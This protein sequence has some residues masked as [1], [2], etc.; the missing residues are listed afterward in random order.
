MMS[1]ATAGGVT[2]GTRGMHDPARIMGIWDDLRGGVLA[3][4][5]LMHAQAELRDILDDYVRWQ[6]RY[7]YMC[8]LASSANTEGPTAESLRQYYLWRWRVINGRGSPR[9]PR[10][11]DCA[12]SI[13]SGPKAQI[14]VTLYSL[15]CYYSRG[16]LSP[17]E[18]PYRNDLVAIHHAYRD[19]AQVMPDVVR[20]VPI[21]VLVQAV[22]DVRSALPRIVARTPASHDI[23]PV[24]CSQR[25]CPG[26]KML[27]LHL[28]DHAYMHRCPFCHHCLDT[29]PRS[30]SKGL[31]G[32][33]SGQKEYKR[34]AR[35]RGKAQKGQNGTLTAHNA[36]Q[37]STPAQKAGKSGPAGCQHDPVGDV[38]GKS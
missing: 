11:T 26:H 38:G 25:E 32:G 24:R 16:G 19:M 36:G 29:L 18:P 34:C 6:L 1:P 22:I 30:Y 28:P 13:T 31:T 37:I 3:G 27:L 9:G 35:H 12:G 8:H 2:T 10:L 23:T 17:H 15:A 20:K 33:Q 4:R 7:T 14:L 21:Q 5:H